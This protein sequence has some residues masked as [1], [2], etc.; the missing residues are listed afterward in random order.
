MKNYKYIGLLILAIGFASC[1]VDNELDAIPEEVVAEVALNTNGLDF[2]S[3]VALGA[4]FTAGYTDGALFKAAQENS[5]PNILAGKFGVGGNFKQP[6]MNDNI[7]GMLFGGS[8]IIQEPRLFF[9]GTAPVRLDATPTTEGTTVLTGGFNNYGIPGAKSF[10]IVA[11]GYG[12][13]AGVPS[14]LANPYY[15]RMATSS[16]S[17]V[18]G[19]ALAQAPTFFTLSEIGGN[20]VLGFAT[21]GGSGEDRTGNL[22]PTTYG[23][24]DITDPSVFK[25][26]FS[27][28]VTALTAGGAKGVVANL[29]YITSLAHFTTV[30][31]NPLDPNDADTGATLVAQ[32]PLLNSIYGAVNQIYTGAG[33]PERSIIFST[34]ETNPVV[35]YDEDATDLSAAITATL[36]ASPT[37]V[38]FVESLGLPA[39]AAPLV[40]GLLGQ[41]YGKAR[42]ATSEDLFVLPSSGVIGTV[43][44][45]SAGALITQSGGLL[46]ANLAGQFSAEGITLPLADQW[47]LT[48]QEQEAIKTATDAYNATIEAVVASNDNVALVDFKGILIEASTGIM[49]DNYT[50]TTS[51]VTGGLVSLDGIHLT[52]RGYA[53]MANKIMEAMDAKFGSNFTTATNGLANAGDYPTNYSPTLR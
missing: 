27:S 9:N 18:L 49:F 45:T 48:P 7:G 8:Q 19:D 21:S 34:T 6:L 36:G 12:N 14:G 47:V 39:A 4:S 22:D 30:P 42:S 3:Y 53:L 43:N 51:L 46:P 2:S 16:T 29:P 40:A 41:Q 11:P 35:I 25:Q 32:I 33:E 28:M 38:P 37:F 15:A 24:N 26:V 5:F 13:L 20:D 10:H 23:S 44:M 31:Y 52:S 50:M 1:E 17:T